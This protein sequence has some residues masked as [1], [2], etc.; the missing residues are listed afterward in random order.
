MKNV[1]YHADVVSFA[2]QLAAAVAASGGA[3]Y[4]LACE[5][6][7]SCCTLLARKDRF[8]KSSEWHT[9]IDYE[10]F[11]DLVASGEAFTAAD[12]TA[13]TPAWAVS[14]A[15]EAGFSPLQ[16]RVKKERHHHAGGAA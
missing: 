10:K 2:R 15:P 6:E 12:Y 4:G 7:H 16:M 11:H 13:K 5:H 9:H 3:D 8:L 14:G 1:P